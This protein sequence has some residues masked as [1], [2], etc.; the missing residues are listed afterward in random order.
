MTFAKTIRA[1]C[2]RGTLVGMAALILAGC[3]TTSAPPSL[4]QTSASGQPIIDAGDIAIAGQLVAHSIL[5]LPEVAGAAKPP[6]VQF[7]GVT[8]AINGPVDTEPYTDL[9]RDRLL[10]ITRLKLRFVERTLPMFHSHK[11]KSRKDLPPPVEVDS[12]ADYEISAELSGNFDDDYYYVRIQFVDIHSGQPLFDGLYRIRKEEQASPTGTTTIT[13]QQ[14]ESTA[15]ESTA[16]Q[17]ANPNRDPNAPVLP[18][19]GATPQ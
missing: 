8:S 18:T 10:L 5:E 11:I 3:A 6:L 9:L 13:T 4:P 19:E 14:I 12:D 15:P 2:G 17:P 1:G 16:P 7:A